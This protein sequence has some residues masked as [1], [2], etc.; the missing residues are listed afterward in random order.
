MR[1]VARPGIKVYARA[2]VSRLSTVDG[3]DL[4]VAS[5]IEIRTFSYVS[6]PAEATSTSFGKRAL[7]EFMYL[8]CKDSARLRMLCFA[9]SASHAL[10]SEN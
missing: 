4:T 3:L 8:L 7:N 5:A 9:C 2:S 6:T 1:T 10:K